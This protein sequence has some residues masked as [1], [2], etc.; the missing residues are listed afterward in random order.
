MIDTPE[1]TGAQD[2]CWGAEARA[3]NAQLVEG[4]RIS[5]EYDVE[6]EDDYGRLLAYVRLGDRDVNALMVERGLACVLRIPPNGE[7][8]ADEFEALEASAR[9]GMVGLW[10]ACAEVTCD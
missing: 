5:L 2:D 10:G 3:F 8:R 7:D 4:E 6:C 9:A 1:I